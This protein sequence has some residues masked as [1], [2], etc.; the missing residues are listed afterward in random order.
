MTKQSSLEIAQNLVEQVKSIKLT[1][2]TGVLGTTQ[3]QTLL[4]NLLKSTAE[5]AVAIGQNKEYEEIMK[6]YEI[7]V[8]A[9]DSA[10]LMGLISQD[11]LA[12]Y[13]KLTDKLWATIEKEN[14]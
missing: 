5:L 6:K 9:V 1:N 14:K 8:T 12:D 3:K 4:E 10:G 11:E 2:A 13:Y 7:A